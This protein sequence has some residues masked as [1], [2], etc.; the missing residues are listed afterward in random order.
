MIKLEYDVTTP[1]FKYVESLW[2]RYRQMMQQIENMEMEA[3]RNNPE[4]AAIA[5]ERLR[6]NKQYQTIKSNIKAIEDVYDTLPDT[7]KVVA[8]N[9]Y[10]TNKDYPW[11]IIAERS[12]Y[13]RRHAMRIRDKMIRETAERLGLW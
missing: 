5:S 11:D 10:F 12:G 3:E 4:A 13:S 2:F 6:A 1:T 7:Y 9:R 8:D